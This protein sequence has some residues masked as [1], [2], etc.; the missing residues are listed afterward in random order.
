VFV[1]GELSPEHQGHSIGYVAE[2]VAEV[3]EEVVHAAQFSGISGSGQFDFAE[4][5]LEVAQVGFCLRPLVFE[6]WHGVVPVVECWR[7]VVGWLLL[8]YCGTR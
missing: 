6:V 2:A 4:V 5:F 8:L 3:F 7:A 1:F